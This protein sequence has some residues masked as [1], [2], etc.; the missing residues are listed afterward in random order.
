MKIGPATARDYPGIEALLREHRLPEAGLLPHL[1]TTLVAR[2]GARVIGSAALE[3]YD[4][5]ALL[6][7]VAVTGGKRRTGLG[8]ALTE[9]ALALARA[10]GVRTVYLLTETAAP[11]F[12]R[13]GFRET[14][15]SSVAPAVG[16]S[17]EF[18]S[19]CPASAVCMS[20]ELDRPGA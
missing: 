3:L 17:V 16:T 10:R 2:E 19:A 9:A 15:R 7:S 1:D 12:S 20:L 11:F 14:P 18:T 6:R 4:R 13:L 8:R 5:C